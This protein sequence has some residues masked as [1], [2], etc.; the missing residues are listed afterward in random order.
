VRA[1]ARAWA[2]ATY[3]VQARL[4]E[5]FDR[6]EPDPAGRSS[7]AVVL[8]VSGAPMVQRNNGIPAGASPNRLAHV[9][10][11]LD[12]LVVRAYDRRAVAD[13]AAGW[14]EADATA[15]RLWPEADAF[16]L[17]EQAARDQIARLGGGV[18]PAAT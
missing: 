14:A 5:A 16:D 8:R 3:A 11:G 2:A 9:R 7:A 6:A 15:A 13:L 12:R 18:V 4:P 10:V 17:A 1:F